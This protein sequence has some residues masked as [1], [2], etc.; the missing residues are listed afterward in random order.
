LSSAAKQAIQADFSG[1][2]Y[3]VIDEKSMVSL[4]MLAWIHAR[5]LEIWPHQADHP[6]AGVSIILSGDFYQLPPVAKK[7][8]YNTARLKSVDET[9]G[10]Y[11]YKLFS[12]TIILDVVMRQ[13][14]GQQSTF[15]SVLGRLRVGKSTQNDW[16]FLTRRCQQSIPEPERDQ[17]ANAVHLCAKRSEVADYNYT[18][19]ANLGQPVIVLSASH[20]GT[21]ASGTSTE[22]GGNLH[23]VLPICIG[24]RV[25]LI[26]NT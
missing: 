8:L 12:R 19:L 17:F 20:T 9:Y 5:C 18:R 26:E 4:R 15:R 24:A 3:I 25:M 13:Q 21:G 2:H 16:V 11:L 23:V 10:Q 6:F 1:V 14:G 22:D 7:P